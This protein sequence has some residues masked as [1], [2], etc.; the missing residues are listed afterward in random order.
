M[1]IGR[2]MGLIDRSLRKETD[3]RKRANEQE[4]KKRYVEVRL[5]R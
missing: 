5:R 2:V 3:N 1:R 4:I